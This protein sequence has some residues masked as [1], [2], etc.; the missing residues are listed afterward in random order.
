MFDWNRTGKDT[1]LG[2]ANITLDDLKPFEGIER[3]LQLSSNVFGTVKLFL[4]FE[5]SVVLGSRPGVAIVPPP[6][7][8]N[9]GATTSTVPLNAPLTTPTGIGP[10]T[11]SVVA[12][13]R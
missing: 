12:G 6:A 8:A 5:P 1:S 11:E 2:K 3:T 4:C 13:G 10:E 7:G 9:S